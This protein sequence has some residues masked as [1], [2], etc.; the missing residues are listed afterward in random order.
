MIVLTLIY[1]IW[2][3]THSQLIRIDGLNLEL[4]KLWNAASA[5]YE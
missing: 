5:E 2:A 1:I 3:A 4:Y